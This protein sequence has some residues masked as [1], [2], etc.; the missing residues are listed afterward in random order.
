MLT[1]NPKSFWS[2]VRDHPFFWVLGLLG[3]LI[4]IGEPVRQAFVHPEIEFESNADVSDPFL[5][6]FA[7]K[8]GSWLFEMGSAQP[9]CDIDRLKT[10]NVTV[11]NGGTFELGAPVATSP[12]LDERLFRC[13]LGRQPGDF[14]LNST[15]FAA[16]HFKLTVRYTILWVINRTTDPIEFTWYTQANPPRWIRGKIVSR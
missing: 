15:T 9:I 6:P 14:R 11:Y 13:P 12:R 3:T 5:L 4:A 16:A 2:R 1:S 7:I 8:N 10:K